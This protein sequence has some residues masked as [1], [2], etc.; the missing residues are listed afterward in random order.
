M[1]VGPGVNEPSHPPRAR[2]GWRHLAAGAAEYA[3]ARRLAPAEQM[4]V[5][6]WLNSPAEADLFWSQAPADQRHGLAAARWVSRER[7]E[8]RDLIRAALLHDVGKG[9]AGLG[10]WGR[11]RAALAERRGWK[12]SRRTEEYLRHGEAGAEELAAAGAEETVVHYARA[13]HGPRPP[14][15]PLRDWEVLVRADRPLRKGPPPAEPAA[16]QAPPTG[17]GR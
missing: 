7:P 6:G 4:E 12:L 16:R 17:R 10:L 2:P 8:H 11:T 5:A 14:E 9:R 15:I 1:Q 3:F 13:H